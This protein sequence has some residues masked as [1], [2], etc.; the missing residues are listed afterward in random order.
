[1]RKLE[2]KAPAKLNLTLDVTGP[3]PNGYH[4]LDMVMHSVSLFDTVTLE[5][6]DEVLLDGPSWLPSDERNIAFLAATRLRERAGTR[7][8]ARITLEKNI[9]VQAGL[10]GGSADAAAVL[11]GLNQLWGLG[12]RPEELR[13][14]GLGLGSDVPF[15][16]SGGTAR[17]RGLGE[18]IEPIEIKGAKPWYLLAKPEGGV[19]TADAYKLYDSLGAGRRPDND[20]FIAALQSGDVE[21]MAEYGGNALEK[22]AIR[23]LPEIGELIKKLKET[24]AGHCAMTGSGSAAFG[25]FHAETDAIQAQGKLNKTYWTAVAHSC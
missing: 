25:V 14:I 9:P 23:I 12:L 13:E 21:G 17:V 24:G 16:L 15:M 20:A 3:A 2:L 7:A 5:L 19:G 6:C 8:G 1:M 11:K 10:G 18:T 22:A 4:T